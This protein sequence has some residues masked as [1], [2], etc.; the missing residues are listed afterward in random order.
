M[1]WEK[2]Y[3]RTEVLDRA[4]DAFWLYGYGST[5]VNDLVE[6]TGIN[7]GSLYNDFTDKRSLFIS[8]LRHYD[9][10]HRRDFLAALSRDH[11]PRSAVLA[12][13]R[14]VIVCARDNGDR[15]GCLLVNTA[16]EV[17]PHDPEI[18]KLVRSSLKE[19][20]LFFREK[21]R[22]GQ[23]NGSITSH[24]QPVD[25]GKRLFSLFLGLRV[26][27]RTCPERSLMNTTLLQAEAVLDE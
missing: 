22:A 12:A 6:V 23:A 16:L 27:T 24:R 13:F 17:S 7:R 19:V 21:Y 15:K 14:Q 25:A 5:S 9:K 2:R 11:D 4:M 3:E 20:E 8:A 26:I 10:V 1:P 18:E